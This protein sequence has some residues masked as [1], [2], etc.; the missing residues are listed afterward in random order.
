MILSTEMKK[1]CGIKNTHA[2]IFQK[3]IA[4]PKKRPGQDDGDDR[5]DRGVA[6]LSCPLQDGLRCPAR[7]LARHNPGARDQKD[8][9]GKDSNRE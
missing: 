5:G 7:R 1:V 9:L 2:E 8:V 6:L 4:Q 3:F